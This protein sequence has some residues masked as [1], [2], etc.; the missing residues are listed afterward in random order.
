MRTVA[1]LSDLH[2]GRDDPRAVD[3]L[4]AELAAARPDL[5]VVSGDLIESVSAPDEP[6]AAKDEIRR[7][8]GSGKPGARVIDGRDRRSSCLSCLISDFG[9]L[10][11]PGG[12]FLFLVNHVHLC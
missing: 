11:Q 10:R 2:F 1:H 6:L 5:V 3:A 8:A 4:R 12:D 7:A 9:Q